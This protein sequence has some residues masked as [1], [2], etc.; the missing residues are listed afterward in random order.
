MRSA[1]KYIHLTIYSI[2][3]CGWRIIIDGRVSLIYPLLTCA[4]P[5]VVVVIV[6]WI[7]RAETAVVWRYNVDQ[8]A[9][10]SAVTRRRVPSAKRWWWKVRIERK[11]NARECCQTKYSSLTLWWFSVLV[12]WYFW[13]EILENHYSVN[14]TKL[15]S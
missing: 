1:C 3:W 10:I 5:G 9:M 6:L 11:G 14:I 12:S 7:R 4:F 8:T 13:N 2:S 15:L